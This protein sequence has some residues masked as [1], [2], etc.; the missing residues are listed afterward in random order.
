MKGI[1]EKAHEQS[2]LAIGRYYQV[3]HVN[4]KNKQSDP[5]LDIDVP[6]IPIWHNDLKDFGLKVSH[7]HLD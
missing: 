1:L 6:I 3:A 7:Y 2:L 4:V 5:V